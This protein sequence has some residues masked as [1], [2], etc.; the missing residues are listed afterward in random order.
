MSSLRVSL[1]LPS[2]AKT[3]NSNTGPKKFEEFLKLIVDNMR[4]ATQHYTT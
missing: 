4:G 2:T 3:V 1:R